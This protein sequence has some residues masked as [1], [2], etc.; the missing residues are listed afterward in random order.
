MRV[1]IR[2]RLTIVFTLTMAVLLTLT[3]GFLY[4]RLGAELLRT[5]DA[6]LLSEADA[7][8]AGIGQQ[9]A[10]FGAPEAAS[11]RGLGSFAQV[12]GPPGTVL[13]TSPVV[14][15]NPAVPAAM[16]ARIHG[17][18]YIDRVVHGIRGTARILV[19]P[20]DGVWVVT[21]TSLQNRDDMLSQLLVL[22]LAGGPVALAIASAAGWALAGGAL[23]PVERM[24]REAAAISVSEPGRRLPIPAGRDEITR[25][26]NT[27]NAMLGRLEAAF[28]RE[29]RFVDDASHELRTPLAIL[30]AELDLAQSRSRTS[31]ELLAAVRSA[32]EEA[33]RLTALAET[34]LVFSRAEG[35]RLL[36]HREQ[37]R[38]DELLQD[39]CSALAVRAAAAGVDVRVIPHAVTAFIDPVRVRQAVDN[40]VSNALRH[41]PRGGQVRV[42]AT[43]DGE[44]VRLT[45]EDTGAGFD[46]AFLP[47]AFDPF[48]TG[49]AEQAGSG[50]GAGLGLAIV[51]ATAEAHGGR[52]AAANRAEGGARVTL[53][54]P[55]AR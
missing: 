52:A 16:L 41:T 50:Q 8:A 28:D 27:L 37:A 11:T 2:L 39:A 38:L 23:R 10:A 1:P 34:L 4:F 25:L 12:L 54:L 40:V 19:V 47:R 53:S 26:G 13:E 29:R 7:V 43:R 18:A 32:A 45:V 35:G 20:R 3:G 24:S 17:P 49:P 21:G 55:A 42:S 44:T 33:D 46:P 6:A 30:K 31:R 15:G 5:V 14:G 36:L 22:M 48:A 51:R 9:G